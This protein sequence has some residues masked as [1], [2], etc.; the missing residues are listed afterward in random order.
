MNDQS[1]LLKIRELQEEIKSLLSEE[2]IEYLRAELDYSREIS[3]GYIHSEQVKVELKLI[4]AMK[5][6]IAASKE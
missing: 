3:N 1:R 6:L 5:N 2:M 4:A